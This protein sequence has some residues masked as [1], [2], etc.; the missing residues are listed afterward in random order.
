VIA[1]VRRP[2]T[3]RRRALRPAAG[4][5]ITVADATV[6]A[7]FAVAVPAHHWGLATFAVIAFCMLRLASLQV[8]RLTLSVLDDLP[9]LLMVLLS[10]MGLTV[11]LRAAFRNDTGVGDLLLWTAAASLALIAQRTASY[12]LVRWARRSGVVSHPT[13]VMGCG[14]IGGQLAQALLDHPEYGLRPVGFLDD[15]PLLPAEDRPV[16]H[17]SGFDSLARVIREHEI[18]DVIV[19]FSQRD[20]LDLIDVLRTCDKLGVEIFTV[21]RLFEVQPAGDAEIVRGLPLTRLRRPT[22]R[23]SSWRLKRAFDV[24]ASGLALVLLSPV[25]AVVAAAVRIEG[26]PGIIF[27][28]KRVGTDGTVFELLKFRSL[29]PVDET[30]SSSMW[31]IANDDRMGR[32]G[33]TIRRLSLDELP[34]LWNILRGD[35]SLVG[36]RPERSFF[37]TQFSQEHREYLPR[38]RVPC[39]LTGWAQVNGLRGDTSIRERARFDNYYIENWSLWFDV[40]IMIRTVAQVVR[41]AGG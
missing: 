21:P 37:V 16:P 2:P 3:L 31:N 20:E 36:P 38:H 8:A 41:M 10:A 25:M 22:Y 13:V 30:E 5:L 19:A 29:K 7:A 27:R 28:Q 14:Q 15:E 9:Q 34:Q 4:R 39:G 6:L 12:A 26:G 24:I 32:V 23:A 35:M 11:A 33:R 1:D 40:K 18:D 17:L